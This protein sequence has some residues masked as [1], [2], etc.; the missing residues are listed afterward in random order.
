MAPDS[1]AF[2]NEGART[3]SDMAQSAVECQVTSMSDTDSPAY[4]L[5]QTALPKQTTLVTPAKH[6]W[7]AKSLALRSIYNQQLMTCI[8]G[9]RYHLFF[10]SIPDSADWRFGLRWGHAVSQ[11]IVH[12]EHM[13]DALVPS[14]GALDADGCFTGTT[15]LDNEGVPTILYTGVLYQQLVAVSK[16]GPHTPMH[17]KPWSTS[18]QASIPL[19][20]C[21]YLAACICG[22]APG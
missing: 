12:W 6:V 13:P 19:Q 14:K 21:T 20:D 2:R 11:D 3:S 18:R 17:R 15:L 7:L 5:R 4:P 8:S 1:A 9:F 16:S 22:S 10:Q